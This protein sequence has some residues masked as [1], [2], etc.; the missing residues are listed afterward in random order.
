[1]VLECIHIGDNIDHEK[2]MLCV[3]FNTSFV[4]SKVLGLNLDDIDAAWSVNK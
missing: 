2:T 3:M 1:V 4:Q